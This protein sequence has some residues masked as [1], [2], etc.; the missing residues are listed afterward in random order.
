M[1]PASSEAA[2]E[3]ALRLLT[4]RPRGA[5][6]LARSLALRGFEPDAVARALARLEQDGLLD[7]LAAARSTVRGRGA[8]YGRSRVERELKVRGFPKEVIGAA[9]EAEGGGRLEEEA[10]RR[11]FDRLWKARGDLAP[12]LRRRRVFHALIRRGFPAEKISEIIRGWYEVD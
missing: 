7:D 5:T 4:I 3:R 12:A 8:R 11:A 10:L 6:E 9:F 2:R 1:D